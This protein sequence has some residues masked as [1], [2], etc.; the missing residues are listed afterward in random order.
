MYKEILI[1]LDGSN[2]AEQVLPYAT[3]LAERLHLPLRLLAC[4]AGEAHGSE[5]WAKRCDLARDYLDQTAAPLADAGVQ[6]ATLVTQGDDA[7]SQIAATVAEADAPLVLMATHGRAGA[8]RWLL[9]S[10]TERV[11]H[12]IHKPLLVVRAAEE[13]APT[14]ARLSTIVVPLDGSSFAE[15]A[16]PEAVRLAE[17]FAASIVLVRALGSAV[18]YY[19]HPESFGGAAR[20]LAEELE[21]QAEDYL[22]EVAERLRGMGATRVDTKVLHGDTAGVLVEFMEQ[23]PDHLV[24]MTSHGRTGVKRWALGS[25]A[26]RVVRHAPGTVLILPAMEK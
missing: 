26:T 3:L 6:V 10:V 24:I 5:A 14:P 9:G 13:E 2:V 22:S 1:P 12:T 19:L 20:D 11:L 18:D 7:A 8:R 4:V 16:L 23:T 15:Q 21:G 17:A 25:I